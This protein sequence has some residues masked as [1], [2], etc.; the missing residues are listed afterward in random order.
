[1]LSKFHVINSFRICNLTVPYLGAEKR[2]LQLLYFLTNAKIIT[3]NSLCLRYL[4][5]DRFMYERFGS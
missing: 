5:Y 3:D 4:I 2:L 1:M